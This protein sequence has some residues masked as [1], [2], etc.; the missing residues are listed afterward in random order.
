MWVVYVSL[1]IVSPADYGLICSCKERCKVKPVLGKDW[2]KKV[3]T[4]LYCCMVLLPI[5]CLWGR[6]YSPNFYTDLDPW[7]KP[8]LY[9]TF[10]FSAVISVLYFFCSKEESGPLD[11]GRFNS[12]KSSTFCLQN[13][14]LHAIR[15]SFAF[16]TVFLSIHNSNKSH[17]NFLHCYAI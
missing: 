8:V 4:D 13:N 10:F 7:R 3:S 15:L 12:N 6:I 17:K 9:S 16:F 1:N 5:A 14:Y 2:K 11:H